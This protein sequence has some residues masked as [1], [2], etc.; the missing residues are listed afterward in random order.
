[1]SKFII[2]RS[3]LERAEF[4]LF[5]MVSSFC[6]WSLGLLDNTFYSPKHLLSFSFTLQTTK[7]KTSLWQI[8]QNAN[9]ITSN[10]FINS[11]TSTVILPRYFCSNCLESVADMTGLRVGGDLSYV[12]SEDTSLGYSVALQRQSRALKGQ[13]NKVDDGSPRVGCNYTRF[14]FQTIGSQS[15]PIYLGLQRFI[16][17]WSKFCRCSASGLVFN[18]TPIKLQILLTCKFCT[19]NIQEVQRPIKISGEKCM[20]N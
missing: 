6:N 19:V 10:P 12:W 1:M 9:E 20:D 15:L 5:V 2:F 7:K 8:W 11:Y 4:S 17:F 14:C 18:L 13:S 3:F 16:S